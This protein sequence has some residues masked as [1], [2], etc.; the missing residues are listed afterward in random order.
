MIY[1]LIVVLLIGCENKT[2]HQEQIDKNISNGVCP[3]DGLYF[4]PFKINKNELEEMSKKVEQGDVRVIEI[5]THYYSLVDTNHT[6][7]DYLDDKLIKMG[8]L[9]LRT[10]YIYGL[11]LNKDFEKAQ[12]F[13][14]KWHLEKYRPLKKL[15]LSDISELEK[16]A[17]KG[18]YIAMYILADYYFKI[19]PTKSDFYYEKLAFSENPSKVKAQTYI[20]SSSKI[21]DTNRSILRKKWHLEYLAPP[22][23]VQFKAETNGRKI[24][25]RDDD[26]RGVF[27]DA[28]GSVINF[29]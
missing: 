8:N 12:K 28:N 9:E 11:E 16:K 5:L 4:S 3:S 22:A 15:L 25:Y 10:N 17:N 2:T 23:D 7:A 27:F 14:K 6:I 21:S 24:E 20:L 26:P 1:N 13:R 18:D 29:E 19:N